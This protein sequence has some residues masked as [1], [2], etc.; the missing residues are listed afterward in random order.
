MIN[1]CRI[2]T[3]SALAAWPAPLLKAHTD[4]SWHRRGGLQLSA[5]S[6]TSEQKIWKPETHG[7]YHGFY[8]QRNRVFRLTFSII[9]PSSN[10]MICLS[11]FCKHLLKHWRSILFTLKQ[12]ENTEKQS[13]VLTDAVPTCLTSDWETVF[14]TV[15]VL[16]HAVPKPRSTAVPKAFTSSAIGDVFDETCDIQLQL[17]K[18]SRNGKKLLDQ[19]LECPHQWQCLRHS[20]TSRIR[21]SMTHEKKKVQDLEEMFHLVSQYLPGVGRSPLQFPICDITGRK[22]LKKCAA[23]NFLEPIFLHRFGRLISFDENTSSYKFNKLPSVNPSKGQDCRAVDSECQWFN[24][25]T[26]PSIPPTGS[27]GKRSWAYTHTMDLISSHNFE[28]RF[29]DLG[30]FTTGAG[31]LNLPNPSKHGQ[32]VGSS[33]IWLF[34]SSPWKIPTINGGF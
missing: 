18:E 10:S 20:N 25:P 17:H 1:N 6:V 15:P 28:F 23:L 22:K 8:H 31:S 13:I 21:D 24:T 33:T 32:G 27:L 26:V 29:F 4:R 2:S 14:R 5:T 11:I 30:V 16:C 34:N 7:F 3:C 19:Q 12:R 9:F